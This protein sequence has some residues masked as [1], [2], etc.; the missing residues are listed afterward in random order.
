MGANLGSNC[1]QYKM[2]QIF[3][4][5]EQCCRIEDDLVIYAYTLEDHDRVL[6]IVLKIEQN[7]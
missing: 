7:K 6:F 1:F 3:G 5:V 4:P 2:D